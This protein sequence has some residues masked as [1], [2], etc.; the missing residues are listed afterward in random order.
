MLYSIWLCWKISFL[1]IHYFCLLYCCCSHLPSLGIPPAVLSP[2]PSH[3]IL[4]TAINCYLSLI[5]IS[6][7]KPVIALHYLQGKV[8]KIL[9]YK[10]FGWRITNFPLSTGP[11]LISPSRI[12][13]IATEDNMWFSNCLLLLIWVLERDYIWEDLII[14]C[15]GEQMI[16]WK[17]KGLLTGRDLSCLGKVVYHSENNTV[18]CI[19][20]PQW[21][22][23]M[24]WEQSRVYGLYSARLLCC[25]GV[26]V[27]R[28]EA[29]GQKC[30]GS[31]K[32]LHLSE[33]TLNHSYHR[34]QVSWRTGSWVK[35]RLL[36]GYF[37]GCSYR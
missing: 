11:S 30:K 37:C 3:F 25:F 12:Y 18:A 7:E 29:N 6:A 31:D 23:S 22:N 28:G 33:L 14:N 21:S 16:E 1:D 24:A 4:H 35:E 26:V 5:H 20:W 34:N 19:Q 9:D 36:R 17:P 8:T 32:C 27:G 2:Y 10:P 15:S 13:S